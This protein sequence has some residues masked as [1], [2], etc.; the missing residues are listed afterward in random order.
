LHSNA[1]G[2]EEAPVAAR[3]AGVPRLLGTFHVDSTYDL[4]R[5]RSS[6]PHR[7]L[8]CLSNHCLDRAVAVSDATKRDWV[9]RTHLPARRVVC[10]HN[11]IDPERFQ[12]RSQRSEAR[13][14]LGLPVTNDLLIGAVGR[15]DAEKGFADLLQAAALLVPDFPG[16]RIAIAGDGPLQQPL[17]EQALR[18]GLSERVHWLGFRRDVQTVYDALDI[19]V[20]PSL[21]EA[22]GYA[23]LEAMATELPAVA[24]RVGGLSEVVVPGS[25]GLLVP[26]RNPPALAAAL[27][28]LL[29]S[30]ELRRRMGHAGRQRVARLFSEREMVRRTLDVYRELLDPGLTVP[31]RSGSA[32]CQWQA[33]PS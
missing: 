23:C 29:D 9:S 30:E 6:L 14:Q 3:L 1:A 32:K 19:F 21:C 27:R 5:V 28:T 17:R 7:L 16:V 12:R 11:G 8:E 22:L 10:I 20:L 2:C 18:L 24:S 26:P 15:L 4:A 31:G 13:A 25:T 33:M